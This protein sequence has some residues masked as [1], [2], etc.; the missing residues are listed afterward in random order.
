MK[1]LLTTM[2]FSALSAISFAQGYLDSFD[3][4]KTTFN[5]NSLPS[6]LVGN[7]TNLY[8]AANDSLHGGEL[9]VMFGNSTT[10]LRLTDIQPGPTNSLYN[11]STPMAVVNGTVFFPG[12]DTTHGIELWFFNQGG[13][14]GMVKDIREGK[15]GAAVNSLTSFNGKLYFAAND[16]ISGQE[17]WMHDPVTN[18]T[19]VINLA[20][21]DTGSN[22]R[23]MYG[24]NNKLYMQ[25]FDYANGYEPYEYDPATGTAK[26][27]ADLIPG[28]GGSLPTDY[29]GCEGKLYFIARDENAGIE[30]FRYD[31]TNAPTIVKDIQTGTAAGVTQIAGLQ[32]FN[33]KLYFAGF[34]NGTYELMSY[35]PATDQTT[36]ISQFGT[37]PSIR[38]L[39]VCAGKLFFTA[40]EASF[41][42]ELYMYDGT[43]SPTR[44]TDIA[45]GSLSSSI[46]YLTATTHALYFSAR[47]VDIGQELF[48][49]S[50]Y[51]K[52]GVENTRFN[53]T[54]S[55]YPN[56]ANESTTL[57]LSLKESQSLS[58]VLTDI[59]GRTVYQTENVLYSAA[60][61]NIN[62][63]LSNL[64][65]GSYTYSVLDSE[66]VM[67]N[68][69]K[70]QKL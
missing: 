19:E 25:A 50:P 48:R 46:N 65:T 40:Q 26:M 15:M 68:S 12:Y 41:G 43:N 59:N 32:C 13:G 37:N 18:K 39:T 4:K 67:M 3:L 58:I 29:C 49:Y 63:P 31:G 60:E 9:W 7:G 34:D 70:L 23:E 54:A 35:D 30:L 27:L 53:G 21:G 38:S 52:L 62:I 47:G 64:P 36:A 14:Y 16:T 17:L 24:F 44:V 22:P 51:A 33:K 61:H 11:T 5:S 10:P 28:T 69:G 1:K 57:K 2:A 45:P 42:S 20:P 6:G 55:A 8:F 66:G 56:P